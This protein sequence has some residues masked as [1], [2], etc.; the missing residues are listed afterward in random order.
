MKI[1]LSRYDYLGKVHEDIYRK[2]KSITHQYDESLEADTTSIV[3]EDMTITVMSKF[4]I[5]MLVTS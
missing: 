3:T 5:N 2:V 1:I 4:V